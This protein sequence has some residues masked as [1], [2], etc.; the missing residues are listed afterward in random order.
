MKQTLFLFLISSTLIINFNSCTNDSKKTNYQI[1]AEVEKVEQLPAKFEMGKIES[2]VG[3]NKAEKNLISQINSYNFALLRGDIKAASAYLYPDAITYFKKFYPEDFTSDDI[4]NDF[5]KQS[6]DTRI[7]MDEVYKKS[8]LDLNLIAS[9]IDRRVDLG[10]TKIYVFQISTLM[11]KKENK[12][13]KYVHLAP[14]SNEQVIGVTFNNGKN[15]S[16]IT[17]NDDT[18]N[19]LRLRFNQ[20]IINKIMNY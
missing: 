13:G 10:V 20:D 6:S 17:L 15:W 18:P 3:K 12:G 11:Y 4:I 9:S 14:E 19:I 7:K 2:Y 5:F 16:F 8:G 1:K